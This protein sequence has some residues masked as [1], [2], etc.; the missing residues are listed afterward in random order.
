MEKRSLDRHLSMPGALAFSVGT[1]VG[2][3][4]LVVTCNTYLAQAG[5]LGSVL[6]LALGAIVMLVISRSYS[7]LMKAYPEAGG[8]YSYTKEIFGYDYGFLA[9]WFMAMTYMAVLWANATSL[10]L[11]GR[12]F[13]GGFF[14][15]GKLYTIF[16]YDVYLGEILL[17]VAALVLIGLLCMHFKKA[18]NVFMIILFGLFSLGILIC[19]GV[20]LFGRTGSM[21]PLFLEDSSMIS[22]IAKIAVISPWAFIGFESISHATEELS[23]ER[24]KIH[25]LLVISVIV[26]LALYVFVTLLSVTAYPS[27]YGSWFDYIKDLDNLSGIEALPPF[28]AAQAYMG[29]AGV[30]VLMIALL[31]LVITSLIGNISALS[32][33]FY[34]MAKDHILPKKVVMLNKKNIPS[35]AILMVVLISV[36]IPFLG[37]TAIG[38]IVDVT[39]IGATLIYGVVSA[40][41]IKLARESKDRRGLIA[42][43]AGLVIMI[44]FGIYILVPNFVSQSTMAKETFLLFIIWSILGFLFF[45]YILRRDKEHRFGTSVVVWVALLSLVLFISLVWMRQSMLA[46]DEEMKT[47]VEQYYETA[48]ADRDSAEDVRF[49]SDQLDEQRQDTTRTL[50]MAMGMFGFVLVI[51]LT[52]H[53]YMSKRSQESEM[54]AN[55]DTM[56]GV[57]NKHA[58]MTREKEINTNIKDEVMGGFAVVVCDVNGL[59]KI[60]DTLGHK[61]GDEYIIAACRMVCEIFQH[62]PVYRIGGDEFVAILGGRDFHMRA[63]LMRILHDRSVQ[64]ITDGGAVVS[65][66]ISDYVPGDDEDFHAVFAR[67]DELMYVEKKLLKSL[68]AVT[69]D[70]E[71]DAEAEVE[72]D[73]LDDMMNTIVEERA[74]L[75]V[76]RSVLIVEDEII[77]QQILGNVLHEDYQIL[78]ASDGVEALECLEEHKEDVALI[79]LDLLMPRMGG[80]ELISRVREDDNLQNIPIIVLTADQKTEVECLQLGA[81]DFIP[82]PY[83]DPEIIRARVNK[84]IELCEDRNIIHSTER[85]ALTKLFNIGHFFR[86]V[87]LFDQHYPDRPADAIVVD[88]NHFHMVNERYGKEYGDEVLRQIGDKVRL[89]ARKL[90]GVGC[91]QSADTFLIYTPHR[92]NYEEILAKLSEGLGQLSEVEKDRQIRLRMGIYYDVDKSIDIERRFDRA[93]MAADSIRG[94]YSEAIGEFDAKMHDEMMFHD[95]LLEEFKDAIQEKQFDVFLQPKYDIRPDTPTLTSAEALVRWKHPELGM[96]SPGVFIPLLEEHGL[97]FDLDYYVWDATAAY[98]RY[99]KDTYGFS[100]PVSVNV[101]RIDMLLPNLKSIFEG[102]LEKYSLTTEDIILEI[103]ESA[104]TGDAEQVISTVTLFREDGFG[105]EMDDFG[106]GYSS[107]GMLSKLP[108]DALKLD[109]SFVRSAFSEN[110]DMRM[111]ELIIDISDRLG[112]PVIA[113]GVETEEQYRALKE[114]GCDIVQGFFFSKPVPRQE[115]DRFIR[116]RSKGTDGKQGE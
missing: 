39:T 44:G 38:W 49:I 17:S 51:M 79:M 30:Y 100:V 93:K 84:A 91:R 74:I 22:Q 83:P 104:Y 7:A 67:A 53:S 48:P 105:I 5:P 114:M 43:I 45:R 52:N 56:T 80:A 98:I 15:V 33:L 68:G 50:L 89:Q 29:E 18:V 113:E 85:D 62:S 12:I 3:G 23:F 61:A 13:L 81:F 60:N 97:I 87:S 6:G 103:T 112:V 11:F 21:E 95:R 116:E 109:M 19:F 76:R 54:K 102:I 2:W 42:G 65:G 9:A 58:F 64:H 16:G 20:A 55:T 28:Y 26:T 73:P 106:T 115:F 59:K 8:A 72:K 92:D 25:R 77:N 36:L 24:K 111:I 41:G 110:R 86:Y 99:C 14:R 108:I 71:S 82:K 107:L 40:A 1:S 90:G 47:N 94:N 96:I 10:P 70:D 66:G 27:Q 57:K 69:R 35:A 32:R 34:S 4:S 63:E 101:S 75:N 46:S 37:R 88:I 31:A 78:Y